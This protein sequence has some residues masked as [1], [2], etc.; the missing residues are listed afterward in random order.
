M[1]PYLVNVPVRVNIWIRPECQRRQFQVLKEAR[2]SI[3]FLQSDG[4]RNEKEWEAIKQN[5][6]L[7]DEGIDWECTVYRLYED[8]NNGLYSMGNKVQE[9]IWNT[10]D[11][12]IFL[13]DDYIPSV[14]YFRFCEV[15]LEK[16]KDDERIECICGM[17]HEG[18]T[19]GV[20]SDYF[21]SREG[22][23]WGIAT[24]KRVFGSINPNFEYSS[25]AY[26]M[27]LLKQRTKHNTFM[28]K[29]I[30]GYVND[31]MYGGHIA[32]AE[33]IVSFDMYGQNR[34]QIIPTKN[35][36]C[37]IG[38][39]ADATHA[40]EFRKLAKGIRRIFNMETYEYEFPLKDAKYIIPDIAYE[41]RRNRI[42]AQGHP[43]ILFW[44]RVET[45]FLCL[46]YDGLSAIIKKIKYKIS[47][48]KILE[49]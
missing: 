41:K 28:W 45:F 43:M 26:T 42:M 7:F 1:K 19:E 9:L 49:R 32:G 3:I 14:S 47:N 23:I 33:F 2:P 11:R 15:L 30:L 44:R 12:C 34:L 21:F 22:S 39:G 6:K 17:N 16:Y 25:D 48:R 31:A 36:I 8:H 13:E 38:Y 46:K 24:W 18:I 37:N 5:R 27:K 4:G 10:V 20:D 40:T 35:M 29:Q